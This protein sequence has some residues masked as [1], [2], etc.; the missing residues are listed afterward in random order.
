[1]DI[2]ESDARFLA[3]NNLMD[4]S[5]LLIKVKVKPKSQKSD[6]QQHGYLRMPAL[7]YVKA[8]DSFS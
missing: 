2:I 7:V 5:L 4:F 6:S 8:K 3:Q 1:L